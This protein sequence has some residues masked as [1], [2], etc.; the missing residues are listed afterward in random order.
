[1]WGLSR[2]YLNNWFPLDNNR[3]QKTKFIEIVIRGK[4]TRPSITPDDP[5]RVFRLIWENY[6]PEGRDY[7][8]RMS[9]KAGK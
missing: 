6:T 4:K 8:E 9:E 5:D 2:K 7:V 1:M 3:K